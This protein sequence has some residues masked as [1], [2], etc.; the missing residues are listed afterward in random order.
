MTQLFARLSR[1][2]LCDGEQSPNALRSAYAG[3]PKE[4]KAAGVQLAL[5]SKGADLTNLPILEAIQHDEMR[6]PLQL[7]WLGGD[8]NHPPVVVAG[9]QEAT[10]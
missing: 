1:R 5:R 2:I 10:S 6:R 4:G 3:Q 9:L 7:Y 8:A